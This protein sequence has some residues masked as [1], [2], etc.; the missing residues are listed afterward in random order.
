MRSPSSARLPQ[1]RRVGGNPDL[2]AIV[3]EEFVQLQNPA[4]DRAQGLGPGLAIVRR[5][6]VLLQHPLK[7]VSVTGRGSMFSVTVPKASAVETPLPDN[8]AS[9]ASIAIIIMVV[10]DEGDVLD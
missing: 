7:L 10:E 1:A 8:R 4:R 3:F 5:T 6:A 9:P 2:Q